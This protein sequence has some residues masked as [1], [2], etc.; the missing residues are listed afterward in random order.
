MN[1]ESYPKCNIWTLADSLPL[2]PNVITNPKNFVCG[3]WSETPFSSI[4]KKDKFVSLREEAKLKSDMVWDIC[5]YNC[6]GHS[7]DVSGYFIDSEDKKYVMCPRHGK[8][9]IEGKVLQSE[10]RLPN[11]YFTIGRGMSE[12]IEDE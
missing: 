9:Y 7:F 10:T 2:N 8:R 5:N 3:K 12:E 4:N 11:L 6:E 1:C